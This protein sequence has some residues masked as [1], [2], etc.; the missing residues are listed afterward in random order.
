MKKGVK[1]SSL[2][3]TSERCRAPNITSG[4]KAFKSECKFVCTWRSFSSFSVIKALI[5]KTKANIAIARKKV[6]PALCTAEKISSAGWANSFKLTTQL[7]LASEIQPDK[8][9]LHF[10]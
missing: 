9:G 1:N 2:I 5:W 10:R 7:K 3:L 6:G 4:L 8:R